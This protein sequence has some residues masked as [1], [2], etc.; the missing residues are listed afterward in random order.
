MD[1]RP[2]RAIVNTSCPITLLHVSDPQFG[3]NHRFGNLELPPPD[4]TFDTLLTRLGDD[5]RLLEREHGL[6][7][8]VLVLSGDLAE[9]GLPREFDDVLQ[10]AEGLTQL[11]N[12]PRH[13]VVLIPGNHDINRAACE[14]YFKN[15]E[16]EEEKPVPPF[17]PKW[18]F[19]ERCFSRFYHDCPDVKFMETEPWTL[20]PMPDLKLVVA[21]LNSTMR[22]S[23]RDD[24][25]YGY[26]GEAQLR[27]F[28]DALAPYQQQGWVR[29][30]ALHHNIRRGPVADDENLRDTEDL[31]RLLGPEINLILHGHT[32]DGKLD[33]LTP[34]LPILSTGSA[35]VTQA[36]RP[37][38]IPN[39]YQIVQL[40]RDHLTR[41]TRA[42]DPRSKRWIGDTRATATGHDWRDDQPVAFVAVGGTFPDADVTPAP[43]T[44]TDDRE[45]SDP[46]RLRQEIP[47]DDFL[48][49]VETVC[50]LRERGVVEVTPQRVGAPP[51]HYLRVVAQQDGVTTVYPVSC[52]EHGVEEQTLERFA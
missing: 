1:A 17:W 40:W 38:E 47:H 4:D 41:W 37:E 21:G 2:A 29:I 43:P 19:Y 30:A 5:L 27:W 23:H 52:S 20:F 7:P 32:H 3:R 15:C 26:L 13:R 49:R 33:W 14:A 8:D 10:F 45:F 34:T 35:A 50:R 22:E 25:H 48:A 46:E 44:D 18:R 16:A 36:A 11:L 24:D 12:L 9:R 42:F 28:A 51:L 39:Q 31:K 6:R